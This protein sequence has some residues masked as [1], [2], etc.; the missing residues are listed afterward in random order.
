MI[1]DYLH[2]PVKYSQLLSL[3]RIQAFGTSFS[4]LHSLEALGLSVHIGEG[5]IEQLREHLERGLPSVRDG[6]QDWEP[7]CCLSYHHKDPAG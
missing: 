6:P 4:R 1:L 5:D 3:L 2:V 7:N